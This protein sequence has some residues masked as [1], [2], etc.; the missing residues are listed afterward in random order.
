LFLLGSFFAA[1]VQIIIYAG[2]V[3]VLFTFI[4]MMLNINHISDIQLTNSKKI[5]LITG[6]FIIFL[7]IKITLNPILN[8]LNNK[9]IHVSTVDT[10]LIGGYLFTN[11]ILLVEIISILLLS[12]LIVSL[13]IE[14]NLF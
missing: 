5:Y 8:V 9:N 7:L 2:A 10:Q 6:L 11:Y 13:Y 3:M 1:S 14:K 12:S 4:V